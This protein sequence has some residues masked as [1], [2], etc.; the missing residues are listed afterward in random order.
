MAGFA[1]P[2]VQ[3]CLFQTVLQPHIDFY[4]KLGEECVK[5][6]CAVDLFLF[7]NSFVDVASLSPVCSLTGGSIYKYQYFEVCCNQLVIYLVDMN[8]NRSFTA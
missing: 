5:A 6:G 8:N 4:T 3:Q 2:F 7:P 1:F